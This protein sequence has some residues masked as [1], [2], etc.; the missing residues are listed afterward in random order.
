[1][2]PRPRRPTAPRSPTTFPCAEPRI[3]PPPRR[4]ATKSP[5]PAP[6][7]WPE[8][9]SQDEGYGGPLPGPPAAPL[10]APPSRVNCAAFPPGSGTPLKQQLEQLVV[11]ALAS[12][13]PDPPPADSVVID[14]TRDAQHGD[15]TTN[16]A[17]RLAKTARRSPRE[18]AQAI[19][20]ALPANPLIA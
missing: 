10:A 8:R 14:R 19:V 12:V 6:L 1:T 2:I 18:L 5:C 7:S 16:V 17:M 11:A 13:L 20:A 4:L 15:F 3:A 9:L